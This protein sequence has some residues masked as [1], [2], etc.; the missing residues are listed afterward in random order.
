MK[1][2]LSSKGLEFEVK[3]VH[4]DEQAQDEMANM[5]MM[6][7]PVTVVDGGPPVV[8]ANFERLDVFLA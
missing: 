6:S 2:Y 5:G 7:I 1:D 4:T 8:G 3:D